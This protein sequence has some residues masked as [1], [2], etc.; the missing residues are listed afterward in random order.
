M[1]IHS[2]GDITD[3]S[4]SR[5]ILFASNG[6]ILPTNKSFQETDNRNNR[7]RESCFLSLN[8]ET[9]E[10]DFRTADYVRATMKRPRKIGKRNPSVP[11]PAERL[12]INRKI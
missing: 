3:F 2:I 6:R 12:Q 4:R 8:E 7:N 1:K 11:I 5:E 10:T 9:R